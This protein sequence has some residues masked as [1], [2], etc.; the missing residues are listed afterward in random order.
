M[1]INDGANPVPDAAMAEPKKPLTE[2]EKK[3]KANV[4][5]FH[6]T[7]ATMSIKTPLGLHLKKMIDSAGS[8]G[9]IAELVCMMREVEAH[10]RHKCTYC[11]GRGHRRSRCPLHYRLR[12]KFR[13]DRLIN[14][15]RGGL[16]V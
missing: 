16:S 4:D 6:A 13:G 12:Q 8:Y 9:E 3:H 15:L 10:E 14:A 2:E 7:V 1:S 11:H 5:K